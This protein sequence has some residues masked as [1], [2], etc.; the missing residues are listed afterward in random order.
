LIYTIFAAGLAALGTSG[1]LTELFEP[2][3]VSKASP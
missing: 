3:Q 2:I 1:T